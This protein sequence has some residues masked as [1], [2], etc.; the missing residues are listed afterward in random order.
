MGARRFRVSAERDPENEGRNARLAA[1]LG[2]DFAPNCL[3]LDQWRG[4]VR[5]TRLCRP[6]DVR[7]AARASISTC[8]SMAAR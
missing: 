5:M 7:I 4:D 1:I 8:S 2:A 3:A 6:A